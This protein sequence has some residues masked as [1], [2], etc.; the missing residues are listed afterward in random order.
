MGTIIQNSL[1]QLQSLDAW[2][3]TYILGCDTILVS[4]AYWRWPRSAGKVGE[5]DKEQSHQH[6]I[7]PIL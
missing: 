1:Q 4:G 3:V 5:A 6:Y 2:V 7:W